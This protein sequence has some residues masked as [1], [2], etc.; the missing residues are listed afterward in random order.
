M[1]FRR[2]VGPWSTQQRSA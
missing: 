2:G 1:D